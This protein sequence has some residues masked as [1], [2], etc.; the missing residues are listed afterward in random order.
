M[1][2]FTATCR[3]GGTVWD[4]PSGCP[5]VSPSNWQK[6]VLDNSCVLALH[7]HSG[8][9][10][11]GQ[12]LAGSYFPAIDSDHFSAF[13]PVASSNW[14]RNSDG[15]VM[16]AGE[17]STAIQSATIAYDVYLRS[18][19]YR[20]RIISGCGTDMGIL[21]ACVN[22]SAIGTFDLY[23]AAAGNNRNASLSFAVSGAGE[24]TLTFAPD[25]KNVSSAGYSACLAW[26]SVAR[27]GD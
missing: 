7:D 16:L 18:G 4:G 23:A 14:D 27:T 10:G 21:T 12:V 9:I 1:A 20:L 3:F 8:S 24:K 6:Y 2:T 22:G 13:F 17:V 25:T 5:I 19:T 11:E 15:N 26:I